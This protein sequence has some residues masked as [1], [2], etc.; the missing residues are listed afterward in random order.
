MNARRLTVWDI[1]YV[2]LLVIAIPVLIDHLLAGRYGQVLL[3]VGFLAA[4]LAL[5]AY[6]WRQGESLGPEVFATQQT[7]KAPNRPVRQ[8]ERSASGRL[9]NW[10]PQSV[11][12]GFIATGVLTVGIMFA[13]G[14]ARVLAGD[15][16]D[17]SQLQQWLWALANNPVTETTRGNLSIAI[18]LHF[19]AGIVWAVIYAAFAEPRLSGPGWRKG[20]LFS[21]V[22]WLLS[23][24]VFLPLVDG[25]FFGASL[26]A[27]PLPV[28]GNLLLHLAYGLT[29]GTVY[30]SQRVLVEEGQPVEDA[31]RRALAHTEQNIAL[32]VLPGLVIG[33][34]IGLLGASLFAPGQDPWLVSVFGAIAGSVVGVAIGSFVSLGNVPEKEQS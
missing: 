18:V 24:V 21:L 13:F 17:G 32:S 28:I 16:P 4:G 19:L 30:A 20:V 5:L 9:V 27:G 3:M 33:G 22:P 25:G 11:T 14:V 2:V 31:E 23:L 26:D 34:L 8:A 15:Q 1:V 29:L 10:V 12:S 7:A 6:S